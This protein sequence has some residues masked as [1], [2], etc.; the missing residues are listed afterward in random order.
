MLYAE[1]CVAAGGAGG[2]GGGPE[3][4]QPLCREE[5]V[6]A[7]CAAAVAGG[8]GAAASPILGSHVHQAGTAEG[9]RPPASRGLLRPAPRRGEAGGRN[10]HPMCIMLQTV[11]GSTCCAW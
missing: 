7:G 1:L 6:R 8:S 5:A 9:L 3:S 2:G 10:G 11:F 4:R